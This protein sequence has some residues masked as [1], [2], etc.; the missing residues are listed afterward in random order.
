VAAFHALVSCAAIAA[1]HGATRRDAYLIASPGCLL[2]E[3]GRQALLAAPSAPMPGSTWAR[4]AAA[5][6]SV[7]VMLL[8][9]LLHPERQPQA[10]AAF[11]GSTGRPDALL[12]WVAAATAVLNTYVGAWGLFSPALL[13]AASV[14]SARQL[15]L[16]PSS[17]A[18]LHQA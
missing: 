4:L 11:A 10:A 8:C 7:G 13:H 2:F 5:Q 18:H 15:T 6:L 17:L 3:S 16:H 9:V 14:P 12:P 1:S